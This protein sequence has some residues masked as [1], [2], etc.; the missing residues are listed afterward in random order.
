M[1]KIYDEISQLAIRAHKITAELVN[2]LN[3]KIVIVEPAETAPAQNPAERDENTRTLLVWQV[4][5][6][7]TILLTAKEAQAMTDREREANKT[8]DWVVERKP[9]N[10]AK[11]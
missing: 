9:G 2:T 7:E 4:K 1:A 5:V 3:D 6:L 8:A 10:T 11:K